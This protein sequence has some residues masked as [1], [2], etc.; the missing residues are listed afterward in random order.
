[1][2]VI[3]GGKEERRGTGLGG[4]SREGGR[5]GEEPWPAPLKGMRSPTRHRFWQ[6]REAWI[7]SPPLILNNRDLDIF[8]FLNIYLMGLVKTSSSS[9]VEKI[10]L[11]SADWGNTL[12]PSPTVYEWCVTWV[13]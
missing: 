7:C 11:K 5:E 6:H 3:T 8:L 13:A 10:G 9:E 12:R 1:M 2:E 4:A